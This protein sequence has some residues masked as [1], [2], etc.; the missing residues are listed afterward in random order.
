MQRVWQ[1]AQM[2]KLVLK[3]HL[4]FLVVYKFNVTPFGLMVCF[5][6]F[7]KWFTHFTVAIELSCNQS[8]KEII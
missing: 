1:I 7:G 6:K 8:V 2:K 5:S 3:L 4:Q